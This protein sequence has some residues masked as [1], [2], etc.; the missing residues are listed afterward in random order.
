MKSW[1]KNHKKLYIILFTVV[2]G[3][4]VCGGIY[5]GI[6]Y[7]Q[8]I[9]K[10]EAAKEAAAQDLIN[11][12]QQALNDAEKQINDVKTQSQQEINDLKT[13]SEQ[14][15]TNLQNQ[16]N[17]VNSANLSQDISSADIE[18][19]IDTIGVLDCWDSKS[20][21][22]FGTGVLLTTGKLMTNWH[23]VSGM[24][25]CLFA[26]DKFINPKYPATPANYRPGAYILD[27]S[28]VQKPDSNLDFAIVPF[29]RN[30]KAK[31]T[32]QTQGA[33]SDE[34]LEVSQLDYR[35]GS[36]TKC[37]KKVT[38]GTPVAI[39]GYP[40]SSINLDQN[41]PPE[42]VTTGAI[43]GYES[44][45]SNNYLVTA[46]VDHGNSGGL[47]LAKENGKICLLG[48]PTWIITGQVESSGIV[49]NINNL[50]K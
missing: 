30:E 5:F 49:Q 42:S 16:I 38:V 26:S 24:E 20:N 37:S 6:K 17:N 19:Y 31:I 12:Q 32:A 25:T 41:A 44:I 18:S 47:A 13:Q 7:Y 28:N 43:S 39:L 14:D 46:K 1:I 2:I 10:E 9:T 8:K 15:K 33:P 36:M 35:V 34:Y 48:V 4:V 45:Q 50:I 40:A 23:V 11:K 27:L 21:E 22:Q 29:T 3:L